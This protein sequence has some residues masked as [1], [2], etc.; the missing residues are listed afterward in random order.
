MVCLWT[1]VTKNRPHSLFQLWSLGLA[2]KFDSCTAPNIVAY[3]P[4]TVSQDLFR[5]LCLLYFHMSV[6]TTCFGGTFKSYL[7][8][9]WLTGSLIWHGCHLMK[10]TGVAESIQYLYLPAAPC[11]TAVGEHAKYDF[12]LSIQLAQLPRSWKP[13]FLYFRQREIEKGICI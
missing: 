8:S 10:I 5:T 3:N 12:V 2:I 6:F 7:L 11:L 13:S 4:P 1:A 9:L